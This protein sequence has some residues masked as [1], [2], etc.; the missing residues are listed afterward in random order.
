MRQKGQS[1]AAPT[2]PRAFINVI[3]FDEQFKAVDFKTSM[4]GSNSTI[5][6]HYSDLQNLVAPKSGFVYIY[7]SNESPVNVFF[8]N[9]QVVHTR[10][11]IL[12]ETHYY[13][14]GLTMAGISSKAAGMTPNKLKYNGKEEQRQEFSDGSG[15]E[16]TDYGARMYDNQ[17]G[18]W[19]TIDPLA[20]KFY[21]WS[22]Y[23]YALDNPINFIDEDGREA[24]PPT[25]QQIYN[26][27]YANSNTFRKL[28]TAAGITSKNVSSS[29]KYGKGINTNSKTGRIS[30]KS[31]ESIDQLVVD[32][33]HELTNRKNRTANNKLGKDVA[34]GTIKPTEYAKSVVKLESVGVGNQVIVAS[35]L[36]MTKL[37]GK[38]D[39]LL[40]DYNSG[41]ID[42]AGVYKAAEANAPNLIIEETGE[43]AIDYYT[44]QGQRLFD[45]KQEEKRLEKKKAEIEKK[46]KELEE[47]LKSKN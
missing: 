40:T 16:W 26:Y 1:N 11:P 44:N 25:I 31:K 20:E 35:E 9:M 13:P 45:L 36:N 42:A 30:L 33:A 34:E 10:S 38:E 28:L 5:K 37:D 8:D 3:F 39:N 6:D 29:V 18:R 41:A 47:K 17:I 21:N 7:C 43:K 15:L 24:K 14:F 12:E 23:V 4:V 27:G 22:P 32:L 2:K 46:I 19:H